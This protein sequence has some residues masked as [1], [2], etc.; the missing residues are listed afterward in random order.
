MGGRGSNSGMQKGDSPFQQ[1]MRSA[2]G[3]L[4]DAGYNPDITFRLPEQE[5]SSIADRH[6]TQI[7]NSI[8]LGEEP[9]NRFSNSTRDE[10]LKMV[11]RE[12][13]VTALRTLHS[14]NSDAKGN[15]DESAD[16]KQFKTEID[17]IR[18]IEEY[19]RRKRKR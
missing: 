18:R 19:V 11:E 3:I 5:F 2:R 12:K 6:Y 9:S 8:A 14:H 1:T 13:L 15:I 4:R 16:V 17:R 10:L 7:Y